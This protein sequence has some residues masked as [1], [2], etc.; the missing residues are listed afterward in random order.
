MEVFSVPKR[1]MTCSKCWRHGP[2]GNIGNSPAKLRAERCE[3]GLWTGHATESQHC[4]LTKE[5]WSERVWK[6]ATSDIG[7]L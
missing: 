4:I 1:S 3:S 6:Y 2:E 7:V 5:A